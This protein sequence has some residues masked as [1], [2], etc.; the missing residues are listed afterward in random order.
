MR[1]NGSS[2]RAST[3]I[4][5]RLRRRG[6][7]ARRTGVQIQEVG[8]PVWRLQVPSEKVLGSLEIATSSLPGLLNR[9][10]DKSPLVN[11]VGCGYMRVMIAVTDVRDVCRIQGPMSARSNCSNEGAWWK[12]F[13]TVPPSKRSRSNSNGVSDSS[14]EQSHFMLIKIKTDI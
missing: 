3:W 1:R 2:G 12:R 13:K 10:F 14:G 8:R 9:K 6:L 7:T 11:E 4:C 5:G